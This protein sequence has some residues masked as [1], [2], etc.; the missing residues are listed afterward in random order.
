M[1]RSLFRFALAA[2]PLVVH[3]Q[4]SNDSLKFHVLKEVNISTIRTVRGT[5]H[6]PEMKECVIYAGKKNEVIVVDSLDANKAVNNTRQILGRIPG[7]NI[8]ETESAGFT[9][10]GIATRGLNPSQSIEMNTRQNGYNISGDI[11][12][13]NEAYYLPPMEAVSRIE[14]VRG[15]SSLQFGSQ[16]GGLVNYVIE[17]A[18][19]NKKI[20]FKTSQTGGSYGLFNSFNSVGGTI[21]KW[22]YYGFVQYRTMQ[23]W[24]ANSEQQQFSGFGRIQYNASSKLSIGVE[25]TLLRNRVRMPG[26][27]TDSLF[28]VD[29]RASYR[30]RN[31]IK[32]PWNVV[33]AYLNYNISPATSLS[34]KSAYLVSNR[35]LVWRNEDGGAGAIDTIDAATGQYAPREV[36]KEF[37][38]N[39]TTEVRMLH[40]YSLGK[41]NNT[42]AGGLRY[43]Y[44]WFKRRGG[45][46]GTTGSDFDLST[47]GD[48]EYA[49]DYSTT[50]IAPFIE[51]IFRINRR[52]TITPG[53]RFE[54]L[55][56]SVNGYVTDS[57]KLYS[58]DYRTRT[59]PLLG[60]GT[61][62][63]TGRFTNVYANISQAYRPIEYGQLTPIGVTSKIDPNMKDAS[64][65][66][67]DLGFRGTIKNYLNFDLGLFYM[68][69]NNRIGT[70]LMT[71]ENGKQYTYRTNIANSVH[72]GIE[73]YIEF[74]ILKFL[75]PE[76]KKG[77]SIFNSF[78]YTDA[79]YTSGEYK[80]NRV[81]ASA[82]YINRAGL[83]YNDRKFSTTFQ[84]SNT[85]D[86]Y[87]DASNVK[88][89]DDPVA[90][91]IPAY[92]IFDL[93]ATYKLNKF[94]VKAGVNNIA[95]KAY[96]TRR[97]DEYPGPGILPAVGRSFYLGISAKL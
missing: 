78:G 46:E 40:Q 93:S 67:A 77:L 89:S 83:I 3:A 25:Y 42:L 10:N 43:S 11:Y 53:F 56:S 15:A 51:N 30:S 13:Y 52:L 76:S 58:N 80:G 33:A 87:G 85:G 50:N 22:N 59:F 74:N 12:G 96:F 60:I 68:A 8:V 91:Y 86:A 66:N 23:G 61:E 21:G 73:S 45:G 17:D 81:E 16:F 97:T 2:V 5:G 69:Y 72:K 48:F 27:L 88:L 14:M 36:E 37:M 29:P 49:L 95:D 57:M 28:N 79:R 34:I 41:M 94:A 19:L 4:Q 55:K 62:Y 82:K 65:Y 84:M 64:G 75:N 9:A 18:P 24:R 47:T 26:G 1:L 92:T 90:G 35:Q 38:N 32:S 44:A 63:K 54:Y 70:V 6:M 20:Q 39:S 31:W 71:D 7:L